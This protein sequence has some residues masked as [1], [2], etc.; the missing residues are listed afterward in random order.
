MVFPLTI[1]GVELLSPPAVDENQAIPSGC[2][3]GCGGKRAGETGE[4]HEI[5]GRGSVDAPVPRGAPQGGE[6]PWAGQGSLQPPDGPAPM[7]AAGVIQKGTRVLI[8]LWDS[9]MFGRVP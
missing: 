5:A 8:S 7:P 2:A 6:Q 1:N 3:C 4:Q 9:L